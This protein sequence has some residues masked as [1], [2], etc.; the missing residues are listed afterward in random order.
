MEILPRRNQK[1]RSNGSAAILE[2]SNDLLSGRVEVKTLY[3]VLL[4]EPIDPI[5]VKLL[6]EHFTVDLAPDP[7]EETIVSLIGDYDALVIRATKLTENILDAGKKLKIVSRHGVGQDN[8]DIPAATHHKVLLTTTPGANAHSV[9]EHAVGMAIVLM[10]RYGEAEKLLRDGTFNQPGSLTGLLSKIGFVNEVLEGKTIALVGTGAIAKRVAEICHVGFGMNVI[11]Y[12]PYVS[13][14]VMAE[15]GIKKYETVEEMLPLCDVL[16]VHVPKTPATENMINKDSFAK[17][18]RNAVIINTS[19]GGIVNEA[20]LAQALC[21]GQIAGAG[22]DVFSPEPPLLDNPLF[23]LENVIMTP[24]I[25]AA[26]DG[27]MYNMSKCAAENI[28]EYLEGGKP[29]FLLN[30]EIY[31]PVSEHP[32]RG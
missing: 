26:S 20:D 32:R 23:S 29:R 13:A 19:R 30:P 22:L 8:L 27:A 14:E 10:K 4:T 12:D 6:K 24:H 7:K 2:K 31:V 16:S 15:H 28:L 17:M 5:G 1:C 11:G 18:R 3:K 21:S 9:A 25:A